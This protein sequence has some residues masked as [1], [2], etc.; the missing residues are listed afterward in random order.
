MLNFNYL[1]YCLNHDF[2]Q[3]F[4]LMVFKR[5]SPLNRFMDYPDFY[6]LAAMTPEDKKLL[7]Y[8]FYC[9]FDLHI[10]P[11]SA[12][13]AICTKYRFVLFSNRETG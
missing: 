4:V 7:F 13:P 2:S 11:K 1:N 8:F 12:K 9:T 10:Q 5:A 6:C 3:L